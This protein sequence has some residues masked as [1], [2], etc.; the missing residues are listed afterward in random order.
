M[1]QCSAIKK[2]P[3]FLSRDCQGTQ[4]LEEAA[5]GISS[6]DEYMNA[7]EE[8]KRSKKNISEVMKKST[9]QLTLV[10]KQK[11]KCL[12]KIKEARKRIDKVLDEME[13]KTIAELE[14]A[15]NREKKL[16]QEDSKV[17]EE[18]LGN[19]NSLDEVLRSSRNNLE[20]EKKAFTGVKITKKLVEESDRILKFVKHCIN[21]EPICFIANPD[22]CQWLKSIG[23]FGTFSFHSNTYLGEFQEKYCVKQP[24]DKDCDVF[25]CHFLTNGEVLIADWDNKK[26]K[27]LD[28]E[29]KVVGSV[30]T[31]GCPND[32]CSVT[33]NM[34]AVT[35][36]IEKCIQFIDL[37][38]EIVLK[39]RINTNETCRGLACNGDQLFVV[40]GGFKGEG[41]GKVAVYGLTGDF[42]RTIERNNSGQRIFSCP[43]AIAVSADGGILHVTDGQRGIV[44]LTTQND[45]ISVVSDKDYTWP[46]GICLDKNDHA[47]ICCSRSNTVAQL[48]GLSKASTI[49][50]STDGIK[51]PHAVCYDPNDIRLLVTL[52]KSNYIYLYQLKT[53]GMKDVTSDKKTDKSDMKRAEEVENASTKSKDGVTKD[54]K[55]KQDENKQDVVQNEVADAKTVVKPNSGSSSVFKIVTLENNQKQG[56]R[57]EKDPD[58]PG[59]ENTDGHSP[60]TQRLAIVVEEKESASET[61]DNKS[62]SETKPKTPLTSNTATSSTGAKAEK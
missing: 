5:R 35:L 49:L 24:G 60:Y 46:C 56:K 23:V 20:D 47:I 21:F 10:E 16:C 54:Q 13:A 41:D 39:R 50:K 11:V 30:T 43:I 25:G 36:P 1:Q 59:K 19:L 57:L 7:K 42:V 53:S 4:L 8:I 18:L 38:P 31:E 58:T 12:N 27:L 17:F 26:V 3:I 32:I 48:V 51:E 15:C 29:F 14:R 44:S 52:K 6:T 33:P 9:K 61:K 28:K 22:M 55:N 37:K 2:P 62:S 40:C 45:V 34:A